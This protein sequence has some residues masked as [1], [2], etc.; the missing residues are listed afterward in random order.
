MF[1]PLATRHHRQG[2]LALG[3]LWIAVKFE[4]AVTAPRKM[5]TFYDLFNFLCGQN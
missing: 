3:L 2:A 4:T 5:I 1:G